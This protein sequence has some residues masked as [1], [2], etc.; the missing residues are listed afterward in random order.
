MTLE[1]DGEDVLAAGVPEGPDDRPRAG[2]IRN[3]TKAST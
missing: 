1:I 2:A 3:G